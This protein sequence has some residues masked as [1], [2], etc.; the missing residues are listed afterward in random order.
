MC[1][2]ALRDEEYENVLAL[3]KTSTKSLAI[4][5]HRPKN[6]HNASTDTF[7]QGLFFFFSSK[8]GVFYFMAKLGTVHFDLQWIRLLSLP[9]VP[10]L[11]LFGKHSISGLHT[12]R[13]HGITKW[14][15]VPLGS[16]DHPPSTNMRRPTDKVIFIL[17][18]S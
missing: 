10:F 14:R 2:V 1:L 16:Q 12:L 7:E 6:G 15:S 11:A 17:C 4:S 3:T 18:L 13:L 5:Q 8:E 9:P